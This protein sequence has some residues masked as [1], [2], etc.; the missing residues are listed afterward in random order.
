MASIPNDPPRPDSPDPRK[1]TADGTEP[2]YDLDLNDRVADESEVS[3]PRVPTAEPA[4]GNLEP[5]TP[6]A[7]WLESA[8]ATEPLPA[9]PA[10]PADSD[11]MEVTELVNEPIPIVEGSD[12]FS[13]GPALPAT[14]V[15]GSDVLAAALGDVPPARGMDSSQLPMAEEVPDSSSAIFGSVQKTQTPHDPSLDDDDSPTYGRV[16]DLTPDASSILAD[17]TEPYRKPTGDSSSIR[18]EA[19]GIGRTLSSQPSTST[20][21]DLNVEEGQVPPELEA[22]AA[23]ALSG[24]GGKLPSESD[25][26]IDAN[27]SEVKLG[28]QSGDSD[29]TSPDALLTSSQ[30]SIFA[31]GNT[32]VPVGSGGSSQL[33]IATPSEDDISVEFSDHPTVPPESA[34]AAL[35]DPTIPASSIHSI[36]NDNAEFGLSS[37]EA[38]FDD[39]NEG[40]GGLPPGVLD[41]SGSDILR[42]R[43]VDEDAPTRRG[44]FEDEG[45]TPTAK[46]RG[47]ALK[48]PSNVS[49]S[50]DPSVEIDWMAGSS[51]EVPV[52]RHEPPIDADA[53]TPRAIAKPRPRPEPTERDLPTRQPQASSKGGWFGGMLV[54]MVLAGGASAGLYFSGLIPNSEKSTPAPTGQQRLVSGEPTRSPGTDAQPLVAHGRLMARVQELA[55]TNAVV[56]PND[57]ELQKAREELQAI[58]NDAETRGE[59]AAVE[60]TIFLGVSH[61]VAGDRAAARQIYEAGKAKFPNFAT[62]FDAALDRLAATAPAEGQSR[63]VTPIELEHCLLC[64]VL[65]QPPAE[66]EP[67][68]GTFFWKAVK[69][70][71]AGNYTEAI[72]EISKA[73]AAHIK[74]ARAMAGRGINPLSDPLEQIFPRACDDLKAYWELRAAIYSNKT[75]AEA[76]KKDGVEKVMKDLADAQ[77]RAAAALKLMTELTDAKAQLAQART[78]LTEAN[79]RLTKAQT[80]LKDA[81]E[82]LTKAN[83]DL[84]TAGEKLTRAETDLKTATAEFAKKEKLA[85]EAVARYQREIESLKDQIAKVEAGRKNATEVVGMLARELQAVKLLPAEYDTA[86][87]VAAQKAAMQRATGPTLTAL[88]PSGMLA[89]GGGGLTSGQ[90]ID[91]AVRLTNAEAA[92]Q[93]AATR[94]ATETKRLMTEHATELKTLKDTHAAQLKTLTDSHAAELKK[95]M[96]TYAASTTKLKDDHAA[97]LKTLAD[98]FAA[99]IKKQSEE[100]RQAVKKLAEGY[101]TKIKALETALLEEKKQAE[102]AA[103]KFKVDLG[104]ALSPAQALDIWLPLLT[105]LR[106]PD[107]AAPALATAT[108]VIATAPA[109]S[110]DSA[111]ARCVAGWACLLTSE[112]PR[113]KEFFLAAQ[114]HSAYKAAT[115]K[116]WVKA[117]EMGLASVDDPLTSYRVPVPAANADAVAAARFLDAGIV[118]Y[119]ADRYADAVEALAEA[120]RRDATNPITWYFLGAARWNTGD[121]E[122]ARRDF[123]QGG[124]RERLT[125]ISSRVISEALAPI[126]GAARDALNLARP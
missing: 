22:A 72:A 97:E 36:D 75:I 94:L 108:K 83:T 96:D 110:E 42:Q 61:E 90:L 16:P 50:S 111:K 109:D 63:R 38:N 27:E 84:K 48:A 25:L 7:A 74:Q 5:I 59:K 66:E 93:T 101:D 41:S 70:A 85:M 29:K 26:F 113:A 123:D 105:D 15:E 112:L 45:D 37:T 88:L 117:V 44:N 103:A 98:R 65:L 62:V 119:K 1:Q 30:S 54:G 19:P 80:E 39:S 4:S 87:L 77:A 56:A 68:A 76:I 35:L 120:A 6:A 12:I 17:L 125:S 31:T 69:L 14:A 86:A 49:K 46:P 33:P 43:S 114:A 23:A 81:N 55:K 51:S 126:Q 47:R 53:P 40:L 116:P 99:D 73:K 107:D 58:A 89:V 24:T 13:E 64:L 95:L 122:A 82:K 60:A 2:N 124:Q 34:E 18:V 92:A 121:T 115:G 102:A 9:A 10:Q 78:D 106:R 71:T 3:D 20:E 67:E 28:R 57:V 11:E 100:H 52:V 8:D 32:P 21:F 91:V 104:N 79:T 118:A